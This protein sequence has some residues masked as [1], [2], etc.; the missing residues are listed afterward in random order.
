MSTTLYRHF[1]GDD[2]L[3]YVGISLS[4]PTRTKAH[5]SGSRWFDQ[6][7]RV[8][9]ERFP[10]RE[11]ALEAE[12]DAIKAEKPKYNIVHNRPAQRSAAPR[13]NWS[14]HWLQGRE[15]DT[16]L[17]AITG[18]DAIVGPA[19]VYRENKI[20]VMIAHGQSGSAGVLTE[21]VLGELAPELP[22]AWARAADTVIAICRPGDL[23]MGQ[24]QHAR[25]DVIK[26]LT[27]HLRTV[28]VFDTDLTLAV[29]YASRFPSEESRE[30]LGDMAVERTGA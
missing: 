29:A 11:A 18:P 12:R 16:L 6:V 30:I 20:S 24:A 5:A 3:L 9:I 21:A 7:S 2:S 4:W 22:E 26:K 1:A 28:E 19:L 8:E 13:E 27:A 10:T 15:E 23:T 25:R 17:S 14:P